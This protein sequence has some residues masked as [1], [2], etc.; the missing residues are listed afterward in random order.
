MSLHIL[1]SG[2]LIAD[3]QQRQGAKGPF[4]IA[5]LRVATADTPTLVSL[6]AFGAEAER[7]LGHGKGDALAVSGRAR[8]TSWTARDGVEKHGLSLIAEQIASAKPRSRVAN[9]SATSRALPS[10]SRAFNDEI[11]PL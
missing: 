10:D 1:A 8:L 5:S 6:I 9:R 3:P 4:T 7:L 2:T 11:P